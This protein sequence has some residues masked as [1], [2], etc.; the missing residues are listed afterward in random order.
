MQQHDSEKCISLPIEDES[1]QSFL[2]DIIYPQISEDWEGDEQR[3][4]KEYL[5]YSSRFIV[6]ASLISSWQTTHTRLQAQAVEE[7]AQKQQKDFRRME[8]HFS[9]FKQRER[10]E[11]LSKLRYLVGFESCSFSLIIMVIALHL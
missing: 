11:A 5:S 6:P 3:L 2:R 8:K 4:M 1:V 7:A 10:E 9:R